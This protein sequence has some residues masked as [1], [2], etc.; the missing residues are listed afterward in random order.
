MQ[1]QGSVAGRGGFGH[2]PVDP[3]EILEVGELDDHLAALRA[4][5]DLDAGG[6][7]V[8]QKP[9]ELQDAGR[10]QPPAPGACLGGVGRSVAELVAVAD[11]LFD[12]RTDSCS[13]T[14]RRARA[15]WKARSGVP[16]S[17]RA[18]PALSS[19]STTR[20]CTAGGSWNNRSVLVIA[21][22]L[23]PTRVES[24]SWVSPKSSMSCW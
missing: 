15:S 2:R 12:P 4:D 5:V 24:W 16:S 14:V 20:R 7:V 3:L 17:A 10:P 11:S 19:P 23:L 21:A 9:F 13:A 1:P 6:Q 8:G 18:C 22:R